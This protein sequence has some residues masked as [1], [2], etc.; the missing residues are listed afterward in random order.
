MSTPIAS[1]R[2]QRFD[3]QGEF[4]LYT[5]RLV[6]VASN[7]CGKRHEASYMLTEIK[8]GPKRHRLWVYFTRR[9][10]PVIVTSLFAPK[11]WLWITCSLGWVIGI[12][13]FLGCAQAFPLQ[14]LS[15]L[16]LIAFATLVAACIFGN[17]RFEQSWFFQ[18]SNQ[19]VLGICADRKN[20]EACELFV[21]QL[22]EAILASRKAPDGG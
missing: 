4:T 5:D 8:L 1:Y 7:L 3:G 16:V 12:F 22:N 9:E 20:S 13:I 15:V 19:R 14:V 18:M 6:T 2:Y 21:K 17:S 10:L 11:P